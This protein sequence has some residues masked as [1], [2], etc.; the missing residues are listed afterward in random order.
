[1]LIACFGAMSGFRAYMKPLAA[2]GCIADST[3]RGWRLLRWQQPRLPGISNRPAFFVFPLISIPSNYFH[4]GFIRAEK[5]I[6]GGGC[7][8]LLSPDWLWSSQG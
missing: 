6:F 7:S 2:V 8:K 1:M 5:I 3:R 4:E